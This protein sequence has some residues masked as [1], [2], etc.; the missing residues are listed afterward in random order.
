MDRAAKG[1]GIL[2]RWSVEALRLLSVSESQAHFEQEPISLR[3]RASVASPRGASLPLYDAAQ[4]SARD[5]AGGPPSLRL[6]A[7]D[8]PE[9]ADVTLRASLDGQRGAKLAP[10]WA[11]FREASKT[12]SEGR[13]RC[14]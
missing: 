8:V 2:R 5:A 7:F 12:S 14:D 13:A 11:A 3:A 6:R 9:L 10:S 4:A 1:E